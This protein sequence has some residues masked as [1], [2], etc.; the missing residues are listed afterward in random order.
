MDETLKAKL[1]QYL[2]KM[3]HAATVAT[4]FAAA[5]IPAT[6]KEY[7]MWL[8]VERLWYAMLF[9]VPMAIAIALR[10][11]WS[12]WIEWAQKECPR[13]PAD[14]FIMVSRLVVWIGAWCSLV[15]GT[16]TWSLAAVKVY[17]APRVVILQEIGHMTGIQKA[18]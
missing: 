1:V 4:D 17:V 16:G 10:N 12:K 6:I 15:L 7:L 5:E 14:F 2:E 11:K 18:K 8:M 9:A 13:D 3:E